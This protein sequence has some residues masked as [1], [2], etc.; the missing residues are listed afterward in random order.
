MQLST[1]SNRVTHSKET[2][3]MFN[4]T[5][6]CDEEETNTFEVPNEWSERESQNK[7][8]E[9]LTFLLTCQR[10]IF[11][12]YGEPATE[13]V[14]SPR[15]EVRSQSQDTGNDPPWQRQYGGINNNMAA[16]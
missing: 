13:N 8:F 11:R 2:Y 16:K 1:V 12:S 14:T 3:I 4:M 7:L 10:L 6:F 15:S 9:V 5:M